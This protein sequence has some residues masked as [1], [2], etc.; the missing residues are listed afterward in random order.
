MRRV[1]LVRHGM[2]LD[3]EDSSWRLAARR[4]DDPP[5]SENGVVQARD[6][7]VYLKDKRIA[8][9]YSSPFLRAVQ[10]AQA[11][12]QETGVR[13]R[14]EPALSEW[15]NPAWFPEKPDLIT[16]EEVRREY[17]GCE[18]SYRSRAV[19][20]YPEPNEGVEMYRRVKG[21]LEGLDKEEA[22]NVVL[23]GHGATV[24]QAARALW[25]SAEGLDAKLCSI[26]EFEKVDG[27]W[28]SKGSTVRHLSI[29]EDE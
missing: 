27:H 6:V 20:T 12:Y 23:V 1:Y 21:F 3:I 2:R 10:T 18:A 13:F 7:G 5:L 16:P 4:P 14:V 19:V 11:I 28:K 8:A 29:T 17:C 25:G 24:T 9:M 22:G 26:T 15:L